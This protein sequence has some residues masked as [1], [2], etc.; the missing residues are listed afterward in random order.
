MCHHLS[1]S[2]ILS[3]TIVEILIKLKIFSISFLAFCS[4]S[5]FPFVVS[6]VFI[7]AMPFT[8]TEIIRF[9]V[10]LLPSLWMD[11]RMVGWIQVHI[12]I[13]RDEIDIPQSPHTLHTSTEGLEARK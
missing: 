12:Y 2:L 6:F 13:T 4:T 11:G 9:V 1:L 10:R 7:H 3:F 5:F 8:V